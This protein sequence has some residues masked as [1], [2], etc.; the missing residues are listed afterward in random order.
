[1]NSYNGMDP[2]FNDE[3]HKKLRK[4]L[5]L[6][7]DK[8]KFEK[9]TKY[10]YVSVSHF[11][12]ECY[13]PTYKKRK[14]NDITIEKYRERLAKSIEKI[15]G[16]DG[17]TDKNKHTKILCL[18]TKTQKKIDN[19]GNVLRSYKHKIELDA[20]QKKTI[21]KWFEKAD[22]VYDTCVYCFNDDSDEFIRL[23]KANFFNK[24]FGDEEKGAPYDIL[25][26]EYKS[27]KTNMKSA[28]SNLKKGNQKHFEM[29]YKNTKDGR[30]IVIPIRSINKD[31]FYG[32]VL[33][34]IRNFEKI[35]N[36]DDIGGDCKLKY[37]RVTDN[38]YFISSQFIEKK[39]ITDRENTVALDE[40]ESIFASFYSPMKCGKIGENM[41]KPILKIQES[42]NRLQSAIKKRKNTKGKKLKNKKKLQNKMN[43]KYQKISHLVDE[44]H[45]QAANYLCQNYDNI[46]MPKFET[47]KMIKNEGKNRKEKKRQNKLNKR[48]KFVLMN[49]AHYRF[50][51]FLKAKAEEYGCHVIDCTEEYTSM[52]CGKCGYLSSEYTRRTKRCPH[53]E[54]QIN[55]DINGS[56]N[57]FIKNYGFTIKK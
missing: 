39:K 47:K 41:R 24:I 50:K 35:V 34:K 52:S 19:I 42:I 38:W 25:T 5:Y 44:V 31:G 45:H 28:I 49:Q 56:R 46:L 43:R 22:Y 26:G 27:F 51:L 48:V 7:N 37:D 4:E 32:S 1:M 13:E 23:S 11:K 18:E 40:G 12:G 3:I 9:D 16:T 21:S 33:G 30:T 36:V 53:C 55:R 2:P 10:G 6:P 14:H 20:I 57:I 8:L 17:M 15:N 29:K 54:H